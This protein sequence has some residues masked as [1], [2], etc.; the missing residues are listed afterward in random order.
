MSAPPIDGLVPVGEIS[1]GGEASEQ[2]S[3]VPV[4]AGATFKP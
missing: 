3:S 2:N 1:T 4:G